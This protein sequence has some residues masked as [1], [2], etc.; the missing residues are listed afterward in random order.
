VACDHFVMNEVLRTQFLEIPLGNSTEF[1][2][3]FHT[4][5]TCHI[6]LRPDLVVF[7]KP[8][9]KISSLYLGPTHRELVP[10]REQVQWESAGS[11]MEWSV[12]VWYDETEAK[13]SATSCTGYQMPSCSELT[14]SAS[15]WGRKF[16]FPVSGSR[17]GLTNPLV[18][19]KP[20]RFVRRRPLLPLSTCFYGHELKLP[21][22][23]IPA[24]IRH[25]LL[26]SIRQR[27]ALEACCRIPS[28]AAQKP[29][30]PGPSPSSTGL[31]MELLSALCRV[32]IR[33]FLRCNCVG[34][35]CLSKRRQHFGL[36]GP[37]W[38]TGHTQLQCDTTLQKCSLRYSKY[39]CFGRE[40][41]SC[42]L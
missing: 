33:I 4:S 37:C 32:A 26:N 38:R 41:E 36:C 27:N 21:Y 7:R 30:L 18:A 42:H 15:A 10:N 34:I 35:R 12:C 14:T 23:K 24:S 20:D 5:G 40:P 28:V 31:P 2:P 9:T 25:A 29:Q 6:A 11:P 19:S 22:W 16:R 13:Q 39:T 1:Q 3:E 17:S 8:E